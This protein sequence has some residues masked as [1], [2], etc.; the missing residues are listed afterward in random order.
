LQFDFQEF[1]QKKSL[2]SSEHPF[3]ALEANLPIGDKGTFLLCSSGHE[4]NKADI[5]HDY[6]AFLFPALCCPRASNLLSSIEVYM[7]A[8][9][10]ELRTAVFSHAFCLFSLQIMSL[11]N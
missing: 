8:A 7:L 1:I 3:G 9:R 2:I 6:C 11:V 4:H 10:S 5:L